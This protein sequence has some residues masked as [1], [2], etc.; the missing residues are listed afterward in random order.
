MI[1]HCP[2]AAGNPRCTVR[3]VSLLAVWLLS[4]RMCAGRSLTSVTHSTAVQFEITSFS[5]ITVGS[6]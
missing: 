2:H 4:H 3:H 5:H 1:R 6:T